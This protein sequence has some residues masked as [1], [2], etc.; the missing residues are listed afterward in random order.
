MVSFIDIKVVFDSV[1]KEILIR[2]MR[3][4]RLREDLVVRCE[5]ILEETVRKE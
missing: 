5:K 1:D 3:K 2:S 4:R